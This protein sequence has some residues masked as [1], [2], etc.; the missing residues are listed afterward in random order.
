[1]KRP[2]G[3]SLVLLIAYAVATY[4]SQWNSSRDSRER[5]KLVRYDPP[6]ELGVEGKQ[7]PPGTLFWVPGPK[8]RKLGRGFTERQAEAAAQGR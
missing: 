7:C 2:W 4:V 8:Y 3:W 6:G 5:R 1:M